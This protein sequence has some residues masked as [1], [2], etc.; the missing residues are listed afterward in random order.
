M[1]PS[2]VSQTKRLETQVSSLDLSSGQ[3]L[4]AVA[5]KNLFKIFNI[6]ENG[7]FADNISVRTNSRTRNLQISSTDI[8]FCP[9]DDR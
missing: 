3:E 4:L 6:E 5:G 7:S 1:P 2:F 8:K 9:T